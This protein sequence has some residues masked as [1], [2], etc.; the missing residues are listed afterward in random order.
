MEWPREASG[1]E[2]AESLDVS[3]PTFNQHLRNAQQKRLDVVLA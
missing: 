2:V 3:S 1:E